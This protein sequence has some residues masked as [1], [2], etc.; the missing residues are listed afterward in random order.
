MIFNRPTTM[1]KQM[2]A[3][4]GKWL[5]SGYQLLLVL[6][7][8]GFIGA[9]LAGFVAGVIEFASNAQ[10]APTPD[11]YKGWMHGGWLVGAGLF[12]VAEILRRRSKKRSTA[13]KRLQRESEQSARGFS[14]SQNH[15]RPAGRLTA[16]GVGS[17]IGAFLGLLLGAS[18]LL[19]WFSLTYSPFAPGGWA[20]SV[21]LEWL[22]IPPELPEP[23]LATDHP[24]ALYTFCVPIALG[25][26]VGGLFGCLPGVKVTIGGD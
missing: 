2:I 19:L 21:T 14:P 3:T 4:F 22:N 16:I 17:L 26:I 15:G 13:G 20:S 12:F 1:I 24:V 7:A 25:A 11:L 10:R 6:A 8:G 23:V 5:W 18:F 9:N